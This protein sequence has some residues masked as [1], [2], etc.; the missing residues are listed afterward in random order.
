MAFL[1]VPST[2]I[3]RDHGQIE[4]RCCFASKIRFYTSNR[5]LEV[6]MASICPSYAPAKGDARIALDILSRDCQER[7]LHT[8]MSAETN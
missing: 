8:A 4:R 5:T 2:D 3:A 7:V 1:R 6:G